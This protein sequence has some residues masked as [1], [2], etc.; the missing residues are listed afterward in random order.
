[1]KSE[2]AIEDKKGR[3][4]LHPRAFYGKGVTKV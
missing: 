1:V 4:E 2:L 3:S